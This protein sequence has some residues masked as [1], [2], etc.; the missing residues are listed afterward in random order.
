MDEDIID[1]VEKIMGTKKQ[2]ERMAAHS[3]VMGD[4]AAPLN[5]M[6]EGLIKLNPEFGREELTNCLFSFLMT[7]ATDIDE[8]LNILNEIKTRVTIIDKAYNTGKARN[9]NG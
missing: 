4:L 1:K 5:A 9:K 2:T 7:H 6:L 3:E 8:A